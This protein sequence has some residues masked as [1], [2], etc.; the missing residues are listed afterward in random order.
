MGKR[1]V[2]S[3]R[4]KASNEQKDEGLILFFSLKKTTIEYQHSF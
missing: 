4:P 2:G 1:K 3:G